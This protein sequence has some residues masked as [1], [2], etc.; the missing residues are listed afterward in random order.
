[1]LMDTPNDHDVLTNQLALHSAQGI[2]AAKALV[3]QFGNSDDE[4][5]ASDNDSSTRD[6]AQED[7]LNVR[8]SCAAHPRLHNL[9]LTDTWRIEK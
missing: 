6:R 1:M 9:F 5:G 3:A 2:G 8:N 4:D 7:Q